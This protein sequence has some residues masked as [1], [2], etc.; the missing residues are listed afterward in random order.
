MSQL[1]LTI[2]EDQGSTRTRIGLKKNV[3]RI[4]FTNGHGSARLTVVFSPAGKIEKDNGQ[5]LPNDKLDLGP[6]QSELVKF[7]G[8]AIGDQVKYTAKLGS[9]AEEDPIVILER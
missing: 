4:Q 6:G 8:P 7:K 2:V 3:N 5:P 1:N 9:F